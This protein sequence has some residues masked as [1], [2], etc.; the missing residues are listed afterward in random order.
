[1]SGTKKGRQSWGFIAILAALVL[2]AAVALGLTNR[3]GDRTK[4]DA[5]QPVDARP[6]E[7]QDAA[8]DA[9]VKAPDAPAATVE[10]SHPTPV[11]TMTPPPTP[12]RVPT[13][14][15][16]PSPSPSLEPTPLYGEVT[17]RDGDALVVYSRADQSSRALES[18]SRGAVVRV[19][20]ETSRSGWLEIE[21]T[22]RG[23]VDG[24]YVT[25][26]L[27]LSPTPEG[28]TTP[29]PGTADVQPSAQPSAGIGIQG[30]VMLGN[31]AGTLNMRKK[32]DPNATVIDVLRHGDVVDILIPTDAYGW[33]KIS[34]D[35]LTGYV[36]GRYVTITDAATED[37]SESSGASGEANPDWEQ[38][39]V[40][41]ADMDGAVYLRAIPHSNSVALAS[42]PNRTRVNI[43]DRET[44]GWVHAEYHGLTGYIN[45]R[46][47]GDVRAADYLDLPY[48]IEIDRLN[49]V[50]RIYTV[51]EDGTY[52]ILTRA[53]LCS[54]DKWGATPPNG[55]Y[56]M[57]GNRYRWSS[58]ISSG[59]YIQYATCISGE[60]L[61]HSLPYSARKGDALK[62]DAY[63]KLGTRASAGCVRL[64]TADAKWIYDNVPAGTPVCFMEGEL[65]EQLMKTLTAPP[66]KGGKWDPT[67]PNPD[68]P[69]YDSTYAVSHPAATP[70]P[71]VTPAP[72][73][74][75]TP[76]KYE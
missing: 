10:P 43:I 20:S 66:L 60:I 23:Y 70:Y 75:W 49:Q 38:Q 48:F 53:M 54:T 59:T 74:P 21:A 18:L 64:L 17:V 33:M 29:D 63:E 41:T 13:P 47:V 51:G 5:S 44:P 62:A 50:V 28:M 9:P 65:D 36:S 19:L 69:D 14:T 76:L 15:P 61:F 42:L 31:T 40:H 34:H 73:E 57:P 26:R 68:N 3:S 32:A 22:Q 45:E 56:K 46:Y 11:P 35:G 39:Q 24:R 2:I 37:P 8:T 58:T 30:V 6:T 72:T 55:T 4:T 7:A 52:S 71:G 1:M 67:D 25:V 12:T 27:N 16:E